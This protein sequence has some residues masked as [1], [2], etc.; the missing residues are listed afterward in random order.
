MFLV[1]RFT[2]L[3]QEDLPH[4]LQARLT[5][6]E[7]R[8][9]RELVRRRIEEHV[10][11]AY[12]VHEAWSGGQR[13]YVDERVLVPRSYIAELL[14]EA[15]ARF[16][17][18]GWT[19]KRIL[20]VGTGSGC[21][22][23]LAARAFPN[24]AVDAVDISPAALEVAA[25]NVAAHSLGDRVNLWLSDVFD[26]VPPA[27]YDLVLANP[28]YEPAAVVDEQPAELAREPRL[29]LDGGPDG[30]ACVRRILAQA[31]AHMAPRGVLVL[32]VGALRPQV[33]AEFHGLAHRVFALHDGSGAVLGLRARDLPAASALP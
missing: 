5:A 20:D 4:F 28:P 25:V 21:L 14:P 6:T 15:I 3:E 23:V 29:A 2:G 13:F 7:V 9:L 11:A 19:P 10:P 8:H 30:M 12:L 22:A 17:G 33:A 31:R 32:E 16:A 26:R 27:A 18:R 1:G 24:A